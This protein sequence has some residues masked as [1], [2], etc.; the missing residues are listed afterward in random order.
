MPAGSMPPAPGPMPSSCWPR[1]G[2]CRDPAPLRS[3]RRLVA[4][5]SA[6][7]VAR[8][9][10]S[11][12][13]PWP[14]SP[15]TRI[16]APKRPPALRPP[17]R[18]STSCPCSNRPTSSARPAR[19]LEALVGDPGY[20]AHLRE[21]G[22]RQEV[23]LGYSDSNKESGFLAA[24]WLLYRAQ[25]GAGPGRPQ[26]R[27]RADPFPWP[28][29]SDRARRRPGGEGDPGPGGGIDR[30]SPEADRTGRGDR[31]QLL[32]PD[33]RPAPPR[34]AGGRDPAGLGRGPAGRRGPRSRLMAGRSSRSWRQRPSPPT[35]T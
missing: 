12:C 23:M 32:Q 3:R 18:S 24:N 30:R 33:D 22:D 2:R 25:V 15:G 8:R 13:W 9:T 35:A 14:G 6:S 7:L 20:R 21:R 34:R 17:A 10:S 31:G 5:S 11:T 1:S 27:A 29:R 28:R 26:A 16:P 19:I 4:G